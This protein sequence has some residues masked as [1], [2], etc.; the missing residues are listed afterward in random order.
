[1][2]GE[3]GPRFS[4]VVP[5]YNAAGTLPETLE[6]ILAQ[7]LPDWECVVVDD[8]SDDRTMEVA[9]DFEARDSR[10]RVIQQTNAGTAGAYNTGIAAA[11]GAFV[12]MCSADDVLLPEH[13]WTFSAYIDENP[14][15]DI[16][17]SNGYLWHPGESRDLVYHDKRHREPH[18]QTFSDVIRVC[19]YSVGAVF[20]RAL[21][22]KVGGYRIG[23]F[24][25]DYD[26]WLRSMAL[27]ARHRYLPVPLSLF[28]MSASQKS[29]NL[30]AMYRSDIRLVSELR[31]TQQLTETE[32]R[33]VDENIAE[34][35]RLIRELNQGPLHALR[36]TLE[37]VAVRVLGRARARRGWQ[38]IKKTGRAFARR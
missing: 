30:E 31:D 11:R 27:G 1:M 4:I 36:T 9:R 15:Y 37:P 6:G 20:R 28:R 21:H 34:R 10:I 12:V 38:L 33:A 7:S 2:T 8:G 23:V 22:M 16:Y 35:H 13:L 17:S 5:A 24:G 14:E 26:F 25:E 32:R 18:S 29:R 3:I 19:F